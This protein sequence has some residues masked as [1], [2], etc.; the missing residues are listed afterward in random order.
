MSEYYKG[1]IIKVNFWG[2]STTPMYRYRLYKRR[3]FWFPELVYSKSYHKSELGKR[4]SNKY[5]SVIEEY[6]IS[7]E[8]WN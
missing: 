2:D 3:K 8:L 6:L 4:I 5:D 7:Q 1:F